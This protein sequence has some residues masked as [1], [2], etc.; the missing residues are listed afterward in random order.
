V[1]TLTLTGCTTKPLGS[2]L[3]SLGVLR[4]ISEQ[5]DPAARALWDGDTLQL[6]TKMSEAEVTEF[7]LRTYS[8]TPI[9]APWNGGSGFYGGKRVGLDMIAA[10]TDTRFSEYRDVILDLSNLPE[11]RRGRAEKQEE[12]GR[13]TAILQYCRNHLS[14]RV[15]EWL[16]AAVG[17]ESDGSRAFAPVLGSGGNEGRLDYTNNFMERVARLVISPDRKADPRGLLENAL[18]AKPT[19]ELQAG[20]AGQ[21]D[22]GRAGGANQG[23]GVECELPTNP[24]EFVLALEGAVAW[25]S[26]LY[27]RHGVSY[28]SFLCSPFTVAA[29]RVGYGSASSGD[30]ARAEIW[31]PVWRR[32]ARYAEIRVLLREGRAAVDGRPATNGLQFAE[33]AT[34]LGI[35][36]GIRSFIRYSLLKRRGDSYVALPAG[37]FPAGYRSESD[38]IREFETLM[39]RLDREKLPPGC[40]GLRRRIDSAIY[41]MLLRGGHVRDLMAALGRLLRRLAVCGKPLD[42]FRGV[43]LKADR[44]LDGSGYGSVAEVRVASALASIWDPEVGSIRENLSPGSPGF[45]W[46]GRDLSERLTSVLQRRLRAAMAAEGEHNPLGGACR[47]HPG[48][49][50]LFIEGSVDDGLIEDLLFAF[51]CLDWTGFQAPRVRTA[52]VLPVY[53]ALQHLFLPGA[54]EIDGE[55]KRLRSDLRLVTLL[56]SG[57]GAGVKDAAEIALRCLRAA[58]LQPIRVPYCG[59]PEQG[60]RMA[61]AL[62]IP[63]VAGRALSAPVFEE[64]VLGKGAV[65]SLG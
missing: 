21:F 57:R 33:A 50:T 65:E 52:E 36:R 48:D 45:A 28:H 10:S 58:G 7:F 42:I 40:D 51:T 35:D 37:E 18:F 60:R 6:H 54:I 34:S 16:D 47:L 38:L 15:V 1:Y 11:V 53:A 19:D 8:P 12:E 26:G 14:D 63:V 9:V 17:I 32:P 13:R 41:E 20:A 44:W 29:S 39:A 30:D 5:A 31:A 22:P 59:S 56:A 49:V 27:R 25:A 61:A 55:P 43:R 64:G 62:L 4:L 2:Y 3:K 23:Q 24:W 46:T